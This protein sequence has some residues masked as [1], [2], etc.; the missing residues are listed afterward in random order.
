MGVMIH[1]QNFAIVQ[2]VHIQPSLHGSSR[3]NLILLRHGHLMVSASWLKKKHL[4]FTWFLPLATTTSPLARREPQSPNVPYV[5]TEWWLVASTHRSQPTLNIRQWFIKQKIYLYDKWMTKFR[6]HSCLLYRV[7]LSNKQK[8]N[9]K[10]DTSLVAI[11]A[12]NLFS[13][14]TNWE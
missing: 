14:S 6:S 10:I 2:S 9:W 13:H 7:Y 1:F 5:W 8:Q 3:V 12:Q 11:G 4:I